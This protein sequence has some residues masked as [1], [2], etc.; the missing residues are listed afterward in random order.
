M[1]RLAQGAGRPLGHPVWLL[2]ATILLA[3][4][5]GK[6]PP[7]IDPAPALTHLGLGEKHFQEG[8]Y[9]QA[10]QAYE[11][12]LKEGAGNNRDLA[13]Y[14][15]AISYTLAEDRNYTPQDIGSVLERLMDRFPES[16]FILP[17]R[18]MAIHIETIEKLERDVQQQ[19]ERLGKL[20]I[21]L[22]RLTQESDALDPVEV[23]KHFLRAGHY[24]K[25]AEVYEIYI[26]DAEAEGKDEVLFLLALVY[27]LP[28][29]ELRDPQKASALL[30]S[31]TELYPESPYTLQAKQILALRKEIAAVQSESAALEAK[32]RQ[33]TK[34]LEELKV[35]DLRRRQPR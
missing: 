33:I 29:N 30:E 21:E 9:S 22:N 17:A 8:K 3:S 28:D 26:E 6:K 20:S 11:Q 15:L 4:A 1:K 34:E 10:A 5:C 18:S 13:L 31:L 23:G 25:A 14:H 12:Y 27:A 19:Q 7:A 24:A 2:M 32:L 16:P 35:V